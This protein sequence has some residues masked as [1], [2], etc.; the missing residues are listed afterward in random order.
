VVITRRKVIGPLV[1]EPN[2]GPQRAIWSAR[3]LLGRLDHTARSALLSNGLR[4]HYASGEVLIHEGLLETHVIIL[5][6]ALVKV[7][8]LL[9]KGRQALMAIRIS[10]DIVGEMSALNAVPRSATVTT[11]RPSTIRTIG[12]E[13]FRTYLE[14]HSGAAIAVA[15]I[16]ADHLRAANRRRVDFASYPVKI[17]VARALWEMGSWYGRRTPA[18]LLID[19]NLTQPELATLCGAADITVH[20]ALRE[21]R[22]AGLIETGYRGF[23]IKDEAALRRMAGGVE[24]HPEPASDWPNADPT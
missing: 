5:E 19:I 7:T 8:A 21:L 20:K 17:R 12:R 14:H 9:P 15:G 16:V 2:T 10:G 1:S 4:R 24:P 18:G 22:E 6:D 3:T 11:C 23:E 13:S